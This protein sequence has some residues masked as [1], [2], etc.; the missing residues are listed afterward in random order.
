MAAAVEAVR[1]GCRVTVI[2]EA[3]RPGGQIYR[4]AHPALEGEE[5]AEPSELARKYALIERF[6][7]IIGKVDYR[8]AASVYAVFPNGEMHFSADGRTEVLRP[9]AIV[10]ATGARELAIPFPGW[11]IPGVMLAGGAQA[12][13]K[14]HRVLPGKRAVI[15]GCGP[16]PLVVAAQLL[17]AGGQV[18]AL[19]SLSPL[20]GML[21]YPLSLWHGREVVREGLRYAST[22]RRAGVPRFTGYVPI[23][24]RGKEHLESV[25]LARVSAEGRIVPG[26]EREIPCDLLAVNY[27]FVANS[28]LAAMA[29]ARMRRD[30][31]IGGWLPVIDHFGRTSIPGLFAAGD[32][33][34]LRGALIA[35][36]DGTIVGA[37]AAT[38]AAGVD[39]PALKSKLSRALERRSRHLQFQKTLRRTLG[40]PIELWRLVT[41]ETIV[42]RCEN[43]RLGEIKGAIEGGHSSLNAVKRNVRSGMGWC[44][45]R[46]CLPAVTS[47]IELSTG[48]APTDMMT[49]RP[50]ARPVSFAA[51]AHRRKVDAE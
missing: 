33:A 47:L 4:Q 12:I 14:S 15:A 1:R 45:G 13:L 51:I 23:R 50:L 20:T 31:L 34:E 9:D 6:K 8:A 25:I 38:P 2:D 42:C 49:P 26:T 39:H 3:D 7:R 19:A 43:V 17:R 16:L 41:D 44:G 35:E 18:A 40:L 28:E 27:G 5:Y 48:T 36:L 29:G 11:T 30:P 32:G 46:T 10:L 24:A 21:R 22:V 37:A